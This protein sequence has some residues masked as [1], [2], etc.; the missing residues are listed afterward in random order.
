MGPKTPVMDKRY[1]TSAP[2][3][4]LAEFYEA[5]DLLEVMMPLPAL[6][7]S[8]LDRVEWDSDPPNGCVVSALKGPMVADD[9]NRCFVHVVNMDVGFELIREEN[10]DDEIEYFC[11]H[12]RFIL[13]APLTKYPLMDWTM[14]FQFTLLK[15]E[16]KKS[17]KEKYECA[18]IMTRFKGFWLFRY[19]I[20]VHNMYTTWGAKYVV[21]SPVFVRDSEDDEENDHAEHE[22]HRVMRYV[23]LHWLTGGRLSL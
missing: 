1:R 15:D 5:H 10:D 3:D 22:H 16:E 17:S 2:G 13:Y 23:P 18:H 9:E 21:S 14:K 8:V 4:P 12:E 7:K 11:R 19:L 6:F 20:V